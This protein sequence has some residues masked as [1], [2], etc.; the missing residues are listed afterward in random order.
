MNHFIMALAWCW[1]QTLFVAAVAIGMSVLA[2]RRSPAASALIAWTGILAT[3]G[4]T[5]VAP[6]PVPRW[7]RG[8]L[9]LPEN[10]DLP[11]TGPRDA[12]NQAA[13]SPTPSRTFQPR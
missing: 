7:G 9:P 8:L 12:V 4:L 6:V 10:V 13:T 11:T 1:V 5:L 3:L 2:M